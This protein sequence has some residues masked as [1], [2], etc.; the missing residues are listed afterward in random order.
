MS[1]AQGADGLVAAIDLAAARA[2]E[3]GRRIADSAEDLDSVARRL[4]GR[5]TDGEW[6]GRAGERAR[7]EAADAAVEALMLSGNCLFVADVL[8]AEGSRLARAVAG[9]DV[10]EAAE[11]GTGNGDRSLPHPNPIAPRRVCPCRRR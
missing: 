2:A 10:A 4:G 6:S 1:P 5:A 9:W 7:G 11:P 3:V 8:R